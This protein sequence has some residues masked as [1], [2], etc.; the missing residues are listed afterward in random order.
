[1]DYR[2]Y[3]EEVEAQAKYHL[4]TMPPEVKE[5]IQKANNDL[6]C[7]PS[8][9]DA[10]GNECSCFDEGNIPFDF[11]AAVKLISDYVNDIDD[12]KEECCDVDEDGEEVNWSERLE[13]SAKDIK[14]ALLGRELYRYCR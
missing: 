1:M 9:Y 6:Y 2:E 4:E 12:L 3:Q 10:E 7:G 11:K 5:A 13:D 8:Y 14:K